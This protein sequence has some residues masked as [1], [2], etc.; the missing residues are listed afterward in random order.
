M[1]TILFVITFILAFCGLIEGQIERTVIGEIEGV[2]NASIIGWACQRS[3]PFSLLVHVYAGGS[4][5]EPSAS[6]VKPARADLPSEIA[7]ANECQ[8][9]DFR[10]NRFQIDLTSEEILEHG[11][12]LIYIHGISDIAGI[13]NSLLQNSAKFRI[14]RFAA[15]DS[16]EPNPPPSNSPLPREKTSAITSI[17]PKVSTTP[18]AAEQKK[19]GGG[20]V[21]DGLGTIIGSTIG[22]ICVVVGAVIGLR[23]SFPHLY[24]SGK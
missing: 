23:R 8:A 11:N 20:G 24:N 3:H 10:K 2:R 12:K 14:P 9:K 22:G 15:P 18:K 16:G 6:L 17:A 13:P 1:Q 7:I 19:S 5:G 21:S 4:A